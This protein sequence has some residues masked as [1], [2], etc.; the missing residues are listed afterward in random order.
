CV[1]VRLHLLE[2]RPRAVLHQR[3]RRL[4]PATAVVICHT[5]N[6]NLTYLD[7][8]RVINI[9]PMIDVRDPVRHVYCG[10]DSRHLPNGKR[11]RQ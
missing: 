9:M 7:P 6:G 1:S 5:K 8:G 3:P 10:E 4:A 2:A 11:H